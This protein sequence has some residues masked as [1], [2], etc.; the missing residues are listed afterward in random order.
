MATV[1]LSE[2]LCVYVALHCFM[3]RC[4]EKHIDLREIYSKTGDSLPCGI[5]AGEEKQQSAHE[6]LTV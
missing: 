1:S 3:L 2:I 5:S 4:C 6:R